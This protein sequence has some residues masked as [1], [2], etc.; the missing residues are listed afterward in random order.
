MGQW[1]M[2]QL[3]FAVSSLTFDATARGGIANV[4][5]SLTSTC[6]PTYSDVVL[7]WDAL[8]HV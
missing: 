6:V 2:T 1:A 4:A 7:T 5:R 8:Q 3:Y